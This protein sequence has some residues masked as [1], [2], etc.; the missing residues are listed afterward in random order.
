MTRDA[1]HRRAPVR[2]IA[3]PADGTRIRPALRALAPFALA[4]L[5]VRQPVAACL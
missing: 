5:V 2:R 3:A 4:V 1:A